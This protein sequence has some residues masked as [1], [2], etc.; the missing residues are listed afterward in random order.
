M[1][2][3]SQAEL[4]DLS[5]SALVERMDALLQRSRTERYG[6]DRGLFP[7]SLVS[8][9]ITAKR[10]SAFPD[11]LQKRIAH[12]SF[13]YLVELE[14]NSVSSGFA[15]HIL[16]T[17]DYDE[18][19]SWLSPTFRLREGAIRQYQIMSSRIAM[20]IFMDLLYCIETGKR[21]ESKRS[22]LKAFRKWLC[23]ATNP[24]HYFAHALLE[25]YRF[26]RSIRTPEVHGTP[27]I[28]KRLLLLQHPSFEELNDAHRLT[29]MLSGCWPPLLDLLNNER[30]SY[31]QI[32]DTEKEWF[33]VYMTG[34]EDDIT[35]KLSAMFEDI[36]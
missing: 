32:S 19:T 14:L 34:S 9:I 7:E 12:I 1:L 2:Q 10:V 29:N 28:P 35:E 23:D 25:A 16:F 22:K 8:H 27:R 33:S 31:M 15:N 18:R 36:E 26:D 30:P 13:A 17:C 3:L 21:L 4:D 5:V 6:P 11:A 20:E 24:F